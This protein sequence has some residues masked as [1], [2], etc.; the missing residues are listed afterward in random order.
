MRGFSICQYLFLG[1]L[2]AC[3]PLPT[4][5]GYESDQL[6]IT[7][8]SEHSWLHTSY[9]QTQSFGRV[10]CN[11]LIVIDDGEALI[12]ETPTNDSIS[13]A[14]IEWVADQ[15]AKVIGVVVHHY[16]V[17][18]LGG[19]PAFHQRGIPS[20]AN[21]AT[22][23]L[24]EAEGW[25]LPQEGFDSLLRLTVGAEEVEIRFFGEGHTEDNITT[26]LKGDQVLFGGC[27]LKSMGAGKGNLNDATPDE[28][29]ATIAR[30]QA[31]YPE[32]K[33]VVPGHGMPGGPELLGFTREMFEEEGE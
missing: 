29:S 13:A 21:A 11:G 23:P 22:I 31:A 12:L 20:Y 2:L 3:R 33:Q 25:E 7:S 26:Y 4:S 24:A 30:V 10:P 27:L 28:W 8:L 9:L 16:H 32:V 17:D 6:R 18:C 14:L 5:Q 1:T 19:L 15:G